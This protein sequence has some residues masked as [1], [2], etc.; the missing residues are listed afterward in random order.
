MAYN[1][2]QGGYG[3]GAQKPKREIINEWKGTGIVRPRSGNDQDP[4]TFYPFQRGGGAIHITVACSEIV[5]ADESGNAKQRTYY[6]P[7]NVLTNK[8]IT[9]QQLQSVCAGMK[10]RVVGKLEPESYTSK[11]TGQKVTS[12]VVNAYVF[13]ILQFPQ[14]QGFAQP[15]Q[16]AGYGQQPFY[17][18]QGPAPQGQYQQQQYYGPQPAPGQ[19]GAPQQGQMGPAYGQQGG[20]APQ[21]QYRGQQQGQYYGPQGGAPAQGPHT[22]FAPGAPAQGQGPTPPYYQAPVP[23]QAGGAPVLEDMPADIMPGNDLH[24]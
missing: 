1:N 4:I 8:N 17:G 12:L 21:G 15:M 23:A 16:G 14:Q 5:G 13:E 9:Q 19:Y 10:V 20:P 3:Q 2:N 6:I 18:P 7:V 22:Q 11:K 24:L